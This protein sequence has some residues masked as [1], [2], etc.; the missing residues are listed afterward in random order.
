[1][2]ALERS[3]NELKLVNQTTTLSSEIHLNGVGTH[4]SV[5]GGSETRFSREEPVKMPSAQKTLD[6][7]D[8]RSPFNILDGLNQALQAGET[9]S[10]PKCLWQLLSVQARHLERNIMED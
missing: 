10:G 2:D 7:P 4:Q 6:S 1:M 3:N 9:A 8:Y 5:K